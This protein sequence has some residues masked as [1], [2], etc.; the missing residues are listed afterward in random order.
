MPVISATTDEVDAGLETAYR[1][2]IWL[3]AR[4]TSPDVVLK[5]D[6]RH[7][8]EEADFFAAQRCY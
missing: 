7:T 1:D 5:Y 8:L 6:P 3:V 4:A 2:S